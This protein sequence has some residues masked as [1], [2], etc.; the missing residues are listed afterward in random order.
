MLLGFRGSISSCF[1]GT[2]IRDKGKLEQAEEKMTFQEINYG[3]FSII[4]P[5]FSKQ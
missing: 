3:S 5:C 2:T 4:I 1:R